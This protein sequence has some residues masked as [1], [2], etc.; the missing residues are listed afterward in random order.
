MRVSIV[1]PTYNRDEML[2]RTIANIMAFESQYNELII[3]DQTKE[4][5]TQT[6]L[7]LD[8]LISDKKIKYKYVDYPNLPNA[9]N[10]AIETAFGDI[11]LFFDD[12][13][14]INK[15]TIPSHVSGFSEQD[16]GCV[17]GKVTIKN[18]NQ[19]ENKSLGNTGTA[20]KIIKSLF[21]MFLRKKAA[22]VGCF[23]ILAN[24]KGNKTL[25]SDTCIGCNMSFRKEVFKKCGL[26]DIKF[27]GNAI[28]EDTDMS[29][30]A[31]RNGYKI[32]YIPNAAVVHFMDN[33]GGTRADANEAYWFAIFKNQCYFYL[34]NFKF[35]KTNIMLVQIFDILRCGRQGLKATRIFRQAYSAA[36]TEARRD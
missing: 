12:D 26:F 11:I 23:G 7:Y 25:F 4:H 27:S 18:T 2:R 33:T 10:A 15:E 16:I 29:V 8:K 24:F 30:R 28:R 6:R 21:F 35:S 1:I 34:K 19:T 36:Y 14:E 17:T 13:V 31:R 20:K 32:A 9:R 5:D 3:V 22:Y